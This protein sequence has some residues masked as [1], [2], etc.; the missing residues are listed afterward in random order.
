M[1]PHAARSRYAAYVVSV[2]GM[3]A[4]QPGHTY[5][6][7]GDL[8]LAER[9]LFFCGISFGCHPPLLGVVILS[10]L[11]YCELKHPFVASPAGGRC[12]RAKR[13]VQAV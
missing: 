9:S 4:S 2:G 8:G 10:A 13:F 6:R 12:R 11:E 3:Y 7:P 1:T 5:T